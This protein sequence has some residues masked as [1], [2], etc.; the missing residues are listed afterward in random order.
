V[1]LDHAITPKLEDLAKELAAK[2]NT[3]AEKEM[4]GLT[5]EEQ[6][7]DKIGGTLWRLVYLRK[8]EIPVPHVV[9]LAK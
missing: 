8:E 4:E 7:I 2:A 9:E 5:P 3:P 6:V 1:E